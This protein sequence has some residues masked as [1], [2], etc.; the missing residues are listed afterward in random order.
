MANTIDNKV[1]VAVFDLDRTLTKYGT[2][3]PFLLSVLRQNP[4]RA[5]ALVPAIVAA[6]RYLTGG[7][8]RQAFK[9]RM[10]G[11][12]LAG[13][14]RQEINHYVDA[15]VERVLLRG[16]R[17]GTRPAIEKHR[18]QKHLLVLATAS[19]DL[20]ACPLATRLGFALT[21]CTKSSWDEA[22]RYCGT[23]EGENCFGQEKLS[24][25]AAALPASREDCTIIAY[26]DHKSD[27]PLLS[28]ADRGIAVNPNRNFKKQAGKL[29]YE[30]VDW[31]IP[32]GTEKLTHSEF[33]HKTFQKL[34]VQ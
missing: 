27:A 32:P 34:L 10:L 25:V 11:L 7:I 12:F 6:L 2:F 17:R 13:R 9:E 16:L 3:T 4:T 5:W 30:V 8:A 22:D 31:D 18:S 21:V 26:S 28:W 33:Q 19:M 1:T 20:W 14:S 15:F 23:I 29:G 24:A